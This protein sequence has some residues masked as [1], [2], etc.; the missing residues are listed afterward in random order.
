MSS[1]AR[2]TAGIRKFVLCRDAGTCCFGGNPK[3]TD[4]IVV[5]LANASGMIYQKQ[6]VARGRHVPSVA[7]PSTG[8]HRN[9]LLPPRQCGAAMSISHERLERGEAAFGHVLSVRRWPARSKTLGGALVLLGLAAVALR[10]RQPAA[11]RNRSPPPRARSIRQRGPAASKWP[12]S[13][14]RPNRPAVRQ[15]PKHLNPPQARPHVKRRPTVNSSATSRS[16]T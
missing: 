4:R 12:R 10:F 1:P 5:S 3:K 13:K 14:A 2:D 7:R 9:G 6:P 11:A 15:R 16:T 8:R